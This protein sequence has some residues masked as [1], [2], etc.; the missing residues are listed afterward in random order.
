[1][2]PDSK[3]SI[4]WDLTQFGP[5]P[6][7][8][9]TARSPGGPSL[10]H[11]LQHLPDGNGECFWTETVS[12]LSQTKPP[13]PIERTSLIN[14]LVQW[15]EAVSRVSPCTRCE[16]WNVKW[17]VSSLCL[18]LPLILWVRREVDRDAVLSLFYKR[19]ECWKLRKQ[20]LN[21]WLKMA[22]PLATSIPT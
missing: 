5:L 21:A 6:P 12:Q 17:I 3:R 14:V 18:Y 20:R 22:V 13:W 1:M 2:G 7:V 11:I 10:R 4:Y 15:N 16:K 19:H 9:T 8:P